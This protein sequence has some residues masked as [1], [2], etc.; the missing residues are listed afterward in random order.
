VPNAG[1]IRTIH[2]GLPE[3]LATKPAIKLMM[4]DRHHRAR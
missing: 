1:W 2:H 4:Q 3:R